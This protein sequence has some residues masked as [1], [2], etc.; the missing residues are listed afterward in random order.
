[1]KCGTSAAVPPAETHRALWQMADLED[2]RA[3]WSTRCG[4]R[5][6]TFHLLTGFVSLGALRIVVDAFG[7]RNGVWVPSA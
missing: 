4:V 3:S 5:G 2:T 7:I 6:M 1:M